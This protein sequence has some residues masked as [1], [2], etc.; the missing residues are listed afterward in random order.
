MR[1]SI[2]SIQN[3]KIERIKE[4]LDTPCENRNEKM[5]L[6]LMSF[7]KDFKIFENISMSIEHQ[8]ICQTMKI[9][10]YKPNEIIVKQGD[11]GDSFFY[12]LTGT[13]NIRLTVKIDTGIKSKEGEDDKSVITVDKNIGVLKS[14]E[15]FGELSL[16]YGTP[17]SATIIS[18]TNSALI[19]IDKAPFDQYVKNIFE[20]QLQD[21]IEFLKICPVFHNITKDLLIK[22]GIRTEVKK[23]STGQIILEEGKKCEFLF[24]I[25]RGTVKI[26]KQIKFIKNE[27][28]IRR[29]EKNKYNKKKTSFTNYEDIDK[30]KQLEN[31]KILDI[32][33]IGPTEEEIN[34]GEYLTRDITLETLKIGDI[35]PSY[36]SLNG[37]Y[38][39][40]TFEADNP[41]DIIVVKL[42]DIQELIPQTYDFIKKYAKPYPNEQFLRKF[43]YYNEAW[44]NYKT[45]LRYNI[46]ADALN[47]DLLQN[48]KMRTKLYTKKDLNGIKLPLIFQNKRMKF[49]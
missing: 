37:L 31:E 18:V 38:L 45:T 23:Y 24:I 43:Y 26:S 44:D 47:R 46:L 42:M 35:F 19:K 4:L 8:N 10:R 49:K 29:Q 11:P 20:N 9:C 34:N 41:C 2:T 39:D 30:M 17:R 16:L 40:V 14:G 6:E 36:Y 1:G 3:Q 21:Q 27:G 7:T 32:L 13:V 12:I 25:R 15:T 28:K 48:S 22:L 5:C 33:S